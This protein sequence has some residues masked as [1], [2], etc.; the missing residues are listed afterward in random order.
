MAEIDGVGGSSDLA[1]E[2]PC[3]PRGDPCETIYLSYASQD[4]EKKNAV[5]KSLESHGI[6]CWMAPRNVQAGAQTPIHRPRY[7]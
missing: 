2:R 5:C 3:R 7:Q 6:S 4:A 1:S